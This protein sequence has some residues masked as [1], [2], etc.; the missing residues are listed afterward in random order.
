[1][2]LFRILLSPLG[3]L[4]FLITFFR[5]TLFDKKILKQNEINRPSIGVGN[6]SMG[7]TGKSV[8]IIY[9]IELLK[10]DY[11]L[12]VIS[13]GYKRKTKGFLFANEKTSPYLIGDEPYMYFK[14]Y[15]EVNVVVSE[16]RAQG[17]IKLLDKKA[18]TELILFD[19]IFQHRWVKPKITILTTTFLKPFFK[20]YI[21]PVGSLR[22]FRL[23]YKRANIIL[24][25]KC[26]EN[27]SSEKQNE[28]INKLKIKSF[29]KVFFCK[30]NYSHKIISEEGLLELEFLNKSSFTLVTGIADSYP[31]TNFLNSLKLNFNHINYPDHHYFIH[32][33]FEKI[34]SNAS[35]KLVLTTEKDYWRLKPIL[36]NIKLFYLPI[37]MG[38]YNK[39][40]QNEFD[41]LIR[42]F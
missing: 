3:L 21:F 17:V 9:L 35:N 37:K 10:K 14:K 30:I 42:S 13:R 39:K 4:Y 15:P 25:T 22:E 41:S 8:L 34:V 29:Q 40:N 23:G 38:F 11:K 24:V 6:L 26:P 18:N 33:D 31:L 7:G 19:D 27:L 5:N 36:K 12:A 28:F 2:K 32:N 16:K 20:D 1:M